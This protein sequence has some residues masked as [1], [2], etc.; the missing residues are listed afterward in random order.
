MIIVPRVINGIARMQ[1]R[2]SSLFLFFYFFSLFSTIRN[3]PFF[4]YSPC[5]DPTDRSGT[6]RSIRFLLTPFPSTF[7]TFHVD[8]S[9]PRRIAVMVFDRG[10]R[11]QNGEIKERE[12]FL[13]F[14]KWIRNIFFFC[15]LR[16]LKV[17]KLCYWKNFVLRF[18]FRDKNK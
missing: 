18:H 1:R 7:A 13:I 6:K 9:P 2:L 5:N 12:I 16:L 10:S 3:P 4:V 14:G 11:I 8:V 17:W 15:I